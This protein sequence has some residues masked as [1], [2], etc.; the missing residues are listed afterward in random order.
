MSG[1]EKEDGVPD[2]DRLVVLNKDE[3]SVSFIDVVSGLTV[4]GVPVGSH[5]RRSRSI[6]RQHG[7]RVE[8]DG[9]LHLG[10]RDGGARGDRPDRASGPSVHA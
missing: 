5:P 9:E 10:R 8:R 4:G 3:D 7:L 1:G 2:A 6:G